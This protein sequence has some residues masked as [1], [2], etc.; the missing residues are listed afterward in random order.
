[1]AHPD[2]DTI[3]HREVAFRDTLPGQQQALD[4]L[5]A[6]SDIDGVLD[7]SLAGPTRNAIRVS[8]ELCQIDLCTIETLL[9]E[10]NFHLDNSILTRIKRALYYYTESIKLENI[11]ACRDQDQS[12]RDI[13]IRCYLNHRHG[14]RD[15]RPEHWRRYL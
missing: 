7:V 14:C 1:M 5:L 4:A 15:A 2:P 8:Y 12:T 13:F 11:S 6:L 3:K 9:F 10:L